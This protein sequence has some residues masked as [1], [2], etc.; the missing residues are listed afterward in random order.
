MTKMIVYRMD[1]NRVNLGQ[2]GNKVLEAMTAP[3]QAVD[4]P[5]YIERLALRDDIEADIAIHLMDV[6]NE[7]EAQA[8]YRAFVEARRG[9]P[10]E[11]II[12]KFLEGVKFGGLTEDE[13]IGL[14][15]EKDCPTI[16]CVSWRVV[17]VTALPDMRFRRAFRQS[18]EF[19]HVDIP[20]A[21]EIQKARIKKAWTARLKAIN[22]DLE[23]AREM[24]DVAEVSRLEGEKVELRACVATLGL[25]DG[26]T[27]TNEIHDTWPAVLTRS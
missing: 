4:D 19:I 6:F 21:K 24:D 5:Q 12:R 25:V 18:E 16:G 1:D 14:I 27:N 8:D 23:M 26:C 2:P 10:R 3:A 13:A 15:A 11:V 7:A 17:D 22:P 9:Q 20:A